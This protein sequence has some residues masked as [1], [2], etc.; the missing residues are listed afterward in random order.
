MYV[1]DWD[2]RFLRCTPSQTW[3]LLCPQMGADSLGLVGS[4][5]ARLGWYAGWGS[6]DHCSGSTV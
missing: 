2:K 1:L 5:L 4:I 6:G 3:R